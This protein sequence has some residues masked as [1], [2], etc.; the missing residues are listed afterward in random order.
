MGIPFDV[1]FVDIAFAR[2]SEQ[3]PSALALAMLVMR[4][5]DGREFRDCTTRSMKLFFLGGGFLVGLEEGLLW[6]AFVYSN[7]VI[8]KGINVI[9]SFSI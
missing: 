3:V 9:P 8:Y 7:G 4:D 1:N 2:H 6:Y 5:A